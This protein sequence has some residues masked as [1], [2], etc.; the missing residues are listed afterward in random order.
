MRAVGVASLE[1][2]ALNESPSILV[3]GSSALVVPVGF[4]RQVAGEFVKRTNISVENNPAAV[5]APPPICRSVANLIHCC[6]CLCVPT[7]TFY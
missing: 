3:G 1:G 4:L 2:R 7:A 5:L 6:C